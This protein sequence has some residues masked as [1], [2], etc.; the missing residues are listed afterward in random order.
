ML[1]PAEPRH[2]R[3]KGALACDSLLRLF[4]LAADAGDGD[5]ES[6][7][8]Y[9]AVISAGVGRVLRDP[10]LRRTYADEPLPDGLR[11]AVSRRAV[12]ESV[13]LP[14]ETVRRK[15]A[16]LIASGHL[17]EQDG[18]V[19]AVG[20]VLEMRQNRPFVLSVIK[21]LERAAAELDRCDAT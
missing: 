13:G 3:L 19:A 17:V 9:L 8:I 11:Q 6:F 10:A 16:A 7:V 4:R 1:Q 12:A 21:E 20:P 5:L 18:G 2:L 14:R 15:I